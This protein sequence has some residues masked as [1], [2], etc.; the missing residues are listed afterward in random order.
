VFYIGTPPRPTDDGDVFAAKRAAALRGDLLN[1]V[2]IELS[3]DPDADLDDPA[4]WRKANV[5]YPHRTPHESMLR[6][7]TGLTNDDDWR[8]EAL[9]IWDSD[10]MMAVFGDG[11]W[12]L[13]LDRDT[14]MPRERL[15]FA[16]TRSLDLA[17]TSIGVA[18]PT[19]WIRVEDS[20]PV[21]YHGFHVAP[22]RSDRSFIE[23][24]EWVVSGAA[25]LQEQYPDAVFVVA[26]RGPAGPLIPA[27]E[28]AGVKVLIAS[29]TDDQDAA[30]QMFD[31][32]QEG[33]IQH[34]AYPEL[35]DSIATAQRY[36]T[37]GRWTWLLKGWENTTLA[38]VSLALWGANQPEEPELEPMF[39]FA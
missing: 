14:P 29:Q 35:D 13:G 39:G 34:R 11:R 37:G 23:G 27:L 3:A 12:D 31:L 28:A 24:K 2:Y 8:H 30:A 4:Q 5:S 10:E 25:A 26:G 18:T 7:R 38:S 16:I 6:L 32:V 33:R 22:A 21:Q 1:G 15:T 36:F 17:R 19:D 20:G 9:G